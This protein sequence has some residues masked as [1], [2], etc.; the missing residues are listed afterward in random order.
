MYLFYFATTLGVF[1][2]GFVTTRGRVQ[3]LCGVVAVARVWM[4]DEVEEVASLACV[5]SRAGV[6]G[7]C[8]M[9][10]PASAV[11]RE[12]VQ[13]GVSL[14]RGIGLKLENVRSRV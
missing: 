3:C 4:N 12:M 14:W 9:S 5:S 8:M 1:G 2:R 7:A 13:A 11:R 10:S 6:C